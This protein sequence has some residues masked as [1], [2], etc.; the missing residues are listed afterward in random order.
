VRATLEGV[1]RVRVCCAPCPARLF[2]ASRT[3]R[4][5]WSV[6][7]AAA[8]W[9]H[10]T[11]YHSCLAARTPEPAPLR[12][13]YKFSPSPTQVTLVGCA[14]CGIAGVRDQLRLLLPPP[15]ALVLSCGPYM[16][17]WGKWLPKATPDS[18]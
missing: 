11:A 16:S 3:T 15:C 9:S 5:Q 14:P 6:V 1:G 10:T 12:P 8:T 2:H 4:L 17:R 7:A 18:E 13:A